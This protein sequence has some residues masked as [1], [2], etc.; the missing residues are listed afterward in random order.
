[1]FNNL[2]DL[3]NF[4]KNKK[5]LIVGLGRQGGGVDAVR[6]F[7][8]L[9]AKLLITD[10]KSESELSLSLE[11]VKDIDFKGTFGRHSL[12]DFK[13]ADF[14]LKGPSVPWD[15]KYI[16]TALERKIPVY[17]NISLFFLLSPSKKIIGI[18]GTR[19][20]TTTTHMIYSYLK[21]KAK[22]YL[23]GNIP[24]S[25][26]LTSLF[27]IKK[28]DWIVMELSS[29]QLSGLHRIKKSPRYAVFTNFYPDHLNF[30]SDLESYFFDK[31]AIF[32]YQSNTDFLTAN[33]NLKDKILQYSPVS[34]IFWFRENDFPYD[35]SYLLGKH[36]K[37]NAAAAFLLLHKALG[38]GSAEVIQHLRDFKPVDF[39]LQKIKEYKNIIFINDT[40][41]TTPIAAEKAIDALSGKSIFL[42]LGGSSK[43]LDFS[44]LLKKLDKVEKIFLLPGSFTDQILPEIKKRYSEKLFSDLP[45]KNLQ[46]LVCKAVSLAEKSRKKIF[47]LFS[48]AAT[49]FAQFKNE[50]DRGRKFNQA[51]F[52]CCS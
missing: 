16:S 37:E 8:R 2:Q 52:K 1:M 33:K 51:V 5:V 35:F 10:L 22:T 27:K 46:D 12:Q 45:F 17:D 19:G 23:L 49:S 24:G 4:I 20:K 28:N 7:D 36:N 29:W 31:S 18:T 25:K 47:I 13:D 11:Q 41:S 3:K 9:G 40:T 34:K 14:I 30:Y 6:F 44:N 50:F 21:K 26:N 32:K 38:F 15:G 48:P 39:R 42:V 43:G